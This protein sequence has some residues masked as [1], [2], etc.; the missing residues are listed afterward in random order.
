VSF[1]IVRKPTFL[2]QFVALPKERFQVL[3]KIEL[4]RAD[5]S[6]REP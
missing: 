1:E 2:N 3:K 5:P 6:P 4:L